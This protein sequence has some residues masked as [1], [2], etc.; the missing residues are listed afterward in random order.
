MVSVPTLAD[1]A[2]AVVTNVT[3]ASP[4]PLAAEVTVIQA[5]LDEAVHPQPGPELIETLPEL[6]VDGNDS[7]SGETTDVQAPVWLPD[8]CI[9][10]NFPPATWIVPVRA[11]AEFGETPK[12]TAPVPFPLVFPVNVIQGAVLAAVHG[13]PASVTTLN[14]PLPPPAGIAWWSGT[15]LTPHDRCCSA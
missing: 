8:D 14:W 9:T 2:F 6:A 12:P 5:A 4:V 15:K 7:A 10:V 13:H 3:V 1:P 11:P